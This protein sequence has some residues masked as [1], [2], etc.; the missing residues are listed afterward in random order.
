MLPFFIQIN[1]KKKLTTTQ[2]YTIAVTFFISLLVCTLKGWVGVHEWGIVNNLITYE[3]GFVKR[4][5]IGTILLP[6]INES[7]STSNITLRLTYVAITIN[8]L[9]LCLLSYVFYRIIRTTKNIIFPIFLS[10]VFFS[11]PFISL[12]SNI[13]G[14]LDYYIYTILLLSLILIIKKKY[15][16]SSFLLIIST[17][18]HEASLAISLPCVILASLFSALKDQSAHQQTPRYSILPS[19][20]LLLSSLAVIYSQSQLIDTNSIYSNFNLKLLSMMDIN[21]PRADYFVSLLQTGFLEYLSDE[22]KKFPNRILDIQYLAIYLPFLAITLITCWFR[23][24][25]LNRIKFIILIFLCSISPL[26]LHTIA[27]DSERIWIMAFMTSITAAW[28]VHEYTPAPNPDSE[29]YFSLT[30]LSLILFIYYAIDRA[31]YM[32]HATIIIYRHELLIWN[33]PSI[34]TLIYLFYIFYAPKNF[35]KEPAA[36]KI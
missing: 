23:L 13:A 36:S 33:I 29:H 18:V 24:P 26:S 9:F 22:I 17:L 16:L 1:M 8:S 32:D 34:A 27:F 12:S 2:R 28:I 19:L 14:Y 10:Y 5:A 11:S 3:F 30:L 31:Y 4:G 6:F 15:I 7:L 20:S 21:T 35:P 25:L